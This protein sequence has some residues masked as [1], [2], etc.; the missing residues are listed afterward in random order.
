M[1]FPINRSMVTTTLPLSEKLRTARQFTRALLCRHTMCLRQ[2]MQNEHG[3]GTVAL[4]R[5]FRIF[6]HTEKV[7]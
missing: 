5:G 1:R 4:M 6:D 2:E 3:R 7:G